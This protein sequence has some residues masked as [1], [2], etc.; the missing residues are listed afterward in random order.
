MTTSRKTKPSK[1]SAAK[2]PSAKVK[3]K[4]AAGHS[5]KK[6]A[7]GKA[8]ASSAPK[9]AAPKAKAPAAGTAK[10]KKGAAVRP[11]KPRAK[12]KPAKRRKPAVDAALIKTIREALVHQRQQL[13]NVMQ[14]TQ[15]QMAE[16]HV[17]LADVV[18]QAS[19]G[20]EDELSL[21]L[22]KIEAAKIDEIVAAIARIDEGSYGLC[23][24]CGRPI[25]RKRLEVLPFALRCLKCKGTHERKSRIQGSGGDES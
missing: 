15:A 1:T 4:A 12:A 21:G 5:V 20:F 8:K 16:K 2:A 11:K 13:L 3:K 22:L 6:K 7:T 17:G 18:D 9:G 25:P 14:S 10:K 23:V 24:D 19:E